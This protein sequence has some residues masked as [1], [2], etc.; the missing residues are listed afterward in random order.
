MLVNLT[1]KKTKDDL[2]N[3]N[4]GLYTDLINL[5]QPELYH[6][7]KS[8]KPSIDSVTID[9]FRIGSLIVDFKASFT[10]PLIEKLEELQVIFM[11]ALNGSIIGVVLHMQLND[12]DECNAN[13]YCH[14][15]ANCL[16]T[17]ASFVC[18]CKDGYTGNGFVCEKKETGSLALVLGITLGSVAFILLVVVVAVLIKKRHRRVNPDSSGFQQR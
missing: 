1:S 6:K 5:F 18:S 15:Q 10:S 4:S 11:N 12:Y 17:V 14:Q 16:N 2:K 13:K 9:G 3:K 8:V 7:W